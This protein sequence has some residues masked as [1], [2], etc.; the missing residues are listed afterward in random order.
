[1][2]NI[3]FWDVTPYGPLRTGDLQECITSV[4]KVERIIELGTELA[5][6]SN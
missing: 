1:M 2:K 6:S 3:V 4:I 5:V